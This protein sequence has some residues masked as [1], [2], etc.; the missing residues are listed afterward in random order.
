MDYMMDSSPAKFWKFFFLLAGL[1]NLLAG[2]SFMAFPGQMLKLTIGQDTTDPAALY[3]FFLFGFT[4][5]LFGI[6]YALVGLNAAANR[7]I[8]VIGGIGKILLFPIALYGYQ[9]GVATLLLVTLTFGD[10][11]WACFF[12]YYL[13][14]TRPLSVVQC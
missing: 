2:G 1:F 6:G 7:G 8:V 5:A 11:I 13:I 4:V 10:V 14:K 12:V 3:V 9:H